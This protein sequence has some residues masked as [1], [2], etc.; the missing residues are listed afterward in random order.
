MNIFNKEHMLAFKK[1]Q[2][3]EI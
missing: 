2:M 3:V 1:K